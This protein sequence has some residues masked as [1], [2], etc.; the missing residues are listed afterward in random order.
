V[1]ENSSGMRDR[2]GRIFTSDEMIASKIAQNLTAM[3]NERANDSGGA[4]FFAGK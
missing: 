3:D 2:A 1:Q 4:L